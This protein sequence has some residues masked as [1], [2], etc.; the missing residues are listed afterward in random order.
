[1][2]TLD[3]LNLLVYLVLAFVIFLPTAIAIF[4]KH[5]HT[6]Y[7]LMLNIVTAVLAMPFPYVI[8][9][10]WIAAF[11]WAGLLYGRLHVLVQKNLHPIKAK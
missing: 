3:L 6:L 11:G 4:R 7:I 1:M 2:E 10:G 9:S 5:P 8:F